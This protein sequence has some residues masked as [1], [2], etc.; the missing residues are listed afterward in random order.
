MVAHRRTRCHAD[1]RP[2]WPAP[3][4]HGTCLF[5]YL[6]YRTCVVLSPCLVACFC[7]VCA[8]VHS[9]W[10][11]SQRPS[12]QHLPNEILWPVVYFIVMTSRF[13]TQ[14]QFSR[15]I[16]DQ[17]TRPAGFGKWPEQVSIRKE[18]LTV[19]GNPR[20]RMLKWPFYSNVLLWHY[21]GIQVE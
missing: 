18:Q 8:P 4:R 20:Y 17:E 10:H 14:R 21:F 9:C 15:Q 19:Y 1:L 5:E 6:F 16:C 13:Q 3:I 7:S 12:W 11:N 2:R